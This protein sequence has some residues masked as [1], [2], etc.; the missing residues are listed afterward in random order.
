MCMAVWPSMSIMA[1]LSLSVLSLSHSGASFMIERPVYRANES[2][3]QVEV[4]VVT[5]SMFQRNITITLTAR[6]GSATSE[7]ARSVVS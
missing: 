4:C 6:N 7:I 5:D 3:P 1:I 2:D